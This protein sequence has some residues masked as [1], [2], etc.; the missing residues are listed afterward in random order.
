MRLDLFLKLKYAS[1][2][3]ILSIGIRYSISDLLS[4]LNNYACLANY[5]YASDTANDVSASSGIA[6]LRKQ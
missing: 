4:D 2:T 1:S 3:M 6:G 5:R